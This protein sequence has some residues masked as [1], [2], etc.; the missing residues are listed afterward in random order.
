VS[1]P[2]LVRRRCTAK[3]LLSHAFTALSFCSCHVCRAGDMRDESDAVDSR[4]WA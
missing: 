4:G 1:L 3:A 2:S